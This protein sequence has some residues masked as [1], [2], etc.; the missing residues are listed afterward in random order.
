M[1][2]QCATSSPSP[3]PSTHAKG[4]GKP[5]YTSKNACKYSCGL[6][7]LT[8][9]DSS[10]QLGPQP[11]HTLNYL[12]STFFSLTVI[13]VNIKYKYLILMGRTTSTVLLE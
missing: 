13:E 1:L 4:W 12:E 2:L 3:T 6:C 10:S 7:H 5:P 11:V 9:A 8:S